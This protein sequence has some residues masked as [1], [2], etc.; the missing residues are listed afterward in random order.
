MPSTSRPRGQPTA[1]SVFPV[2]YARTWAAQKY[3]HGWPA[4]AATELPVSVSFLY[5]LT[6][7]VF[8]SKEIGG[9]DSVNEAFRCEA[10]ALPSG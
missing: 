4:S 8:I 10:I 7:L 3:Q 5:D 9:C 2:C 1:S 6:S